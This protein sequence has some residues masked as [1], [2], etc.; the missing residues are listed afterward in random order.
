LS[1]I[2]F[3]HDFILGKTDLKIFSIKDDDKRDICCFFGLQRFVNNW[4]IG[5]IIRL[6][7]L[8]SESRT[9]IGHF[10]NMLRK[11][12]VT[13]GPDALRE[14][15]VEEKVLK[16]IPYGRQQIVY[17]S[18]EMIDDDKYRIDFVNSPEIIPYI[19]ITSK[20]V[21]DKEIRLSSS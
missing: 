13:F 6:T 15:K 2:N 16:I 21:G 4:N 14:I 7:D 1:V 18:L 8:A 11:L 10:K 12:P 17:G 20:S 19:S 5:K 9:D 3:A